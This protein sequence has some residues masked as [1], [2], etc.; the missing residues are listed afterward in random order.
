VVAAATAAALSQSSSFLYGASTAHIHAYINTH[1]LKKK[2]GKREG[3]PTEEGADS[4]DRHVR[5]EGEPLAVSFFLSFVF[6]FACFRILFLLLIFGMRFF[7]C[8]HLSPFEMSLPSFFFFIPARVPTLC[9]ALRVV[10]VITDA[11][12]SFSLQKKKKSEAER[13]VMS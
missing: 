3:A 1:V 5:A 6:P 13:N 11:L 7:S 4:A 12:P 10:L 2:E 9:A 8:N